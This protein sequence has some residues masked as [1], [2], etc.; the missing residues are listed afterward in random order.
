MIILPH[1]SRITIDLAICRW[2]CVHLVICFNHYYF[3]ISIIIFFILCR[4]C[5]ALVCAA[6][7]F[8]ASLHAEELQCQSLN[9]TIPN[10]HKLM[11]CG[12]S[13][14]ARF[15][16]STLFTLQLHNLLLFKRVIT[17]CS[18][19]TDLMGCSLF[20]PRCTE[21]IKG[22]YLPCRGVC[23][24]WV[25]AC[26]DAIR[27][28]VTFEWTAGIC[29]ILPEKDDPQTTK[30]YRGRCFVPPGYKRSGQSK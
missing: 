13:H 24:D 4:F 1:S 9:D 26:K 10:F 30:G 2:Y 27:A 22:P 11:K 15:N 7:F 25:N 23:H 17:N 3:Y 18:A 16:D 6:F 14:T 20:V 8:A 19:L 5:I 29:D 21:E 28:S 12:Y